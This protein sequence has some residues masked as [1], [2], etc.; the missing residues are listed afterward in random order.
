MA[1]TKKPSKSKPGV[2]VRDLKP[3]KNPKGGAVDMFHKAT[4]SPAIKI[5]SMS[6]LSTGALTDKS[7]YLKIK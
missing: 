4:L 5:D 1:K 3:E 7:S 2:K 6:K